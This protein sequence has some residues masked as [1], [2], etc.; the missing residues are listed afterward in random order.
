VN[1]N[2]ILDS[3]SRTV[4]NSREEVYEDNWS[5]LPGFNNDRFCVEYIQNCTRV[6]KI[7]S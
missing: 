4:N 6:S 3:T 7:D 2:E 5:G 1:H